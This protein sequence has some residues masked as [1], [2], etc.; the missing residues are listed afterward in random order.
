MDLKVTILG[1][2]SRGN[3]AVVGA[4][5]L[6]LLVDAGFSRRELLRRL[7]ACRIDP[8]TIRAVLLTHEHEDHVSG[9]RVLCNELNIPVCAA[10]GTASRL[11]DR[12]QLPAKV[13]L[14][15]PGDEFMVCGYK[16]RAFPVLH[17]AVDPVGFVISD[18]VSRVGVATDLG[19]VS[20][21]VKQSLAN[22]H[23][24]LLEANYDLEML[25]RSHRPLDLKRRI[26]GQAGHLNNLD[27]M[28]ALEELV[29]SR[30]EHVVLTHVS[31]E[32]NRYELV[33]ELGSQ[34]LARLNRPDVRLNVAEQDTPLEVT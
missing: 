33:S 9:L 13:M 31:R 10:A 34:L 25:R 26:L 6:N 29:G 17:D 4:G 7:E 2:G 20:G 15:A 23:A 5:G 30:T 1:S 16:V 22:C 12:G 3:S 27:A 11:R 8:L 32:C 24:L 21:A 19:C 18:G 14:F 28:R